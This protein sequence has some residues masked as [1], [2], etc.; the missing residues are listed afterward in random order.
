MP[1]CEFAGNSLNNTTQTPDIDRRD[2]S[3][4]IVTGQRMPRCAL[5]E[6]VGYTALQIRCLL[7]DDPDKCPVVEYYAHEINLEEA[8]NRLSDLGASLTLR[9]DPRSK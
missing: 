6:D 9:L 8:N 3:G 5:L 4:L 7:V 1:T 2:T